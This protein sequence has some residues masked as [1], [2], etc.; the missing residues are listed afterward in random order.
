MSRRTKHAERGYTLA[1]V[2]MSLAILGIGATGVIALQKTTIIGNTGARNLSTANAIAITWA[3]RLRADASQWTSAE[4]P[5]LTSTRW[6]NARTVAPAAIGEF[7][8]PAEIADYGSPAADV[9]GVD[10]YQN[11]PE[12]QGFCTEIRLRQMYPTLIRAEIRV[13]WDRGGNPVECNLA[14]DPALD[15]GRYGFVYLTTG[16]HQTVV[17]D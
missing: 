15:L 12:A 4:T 6:L 9:L 3:E 7:A 14:D 5:T 1:E 16:I 17:A 2:M 8:A 13:Y 10:L 11:D